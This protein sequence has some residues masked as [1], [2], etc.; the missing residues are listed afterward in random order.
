MGRK[1]RARKWVPLVATL[2]GVMGLLAPATAPVIGQTNPP[3]SAQQSAE[4]EEAKR[5]NEQARKLYN[6][7]QYA[8]AIPIEERALAIREKVLGKEHPDVAQS[9]NNL[10]LLYQDQGNYSQ[11]EPSKPKLTN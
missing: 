2:I 11:A 8:A 7:G 5:L 4:L 1:A 3:L 6:Q 10:A 9:L